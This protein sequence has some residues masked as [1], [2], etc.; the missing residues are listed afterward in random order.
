MD[1]VIPENMHVGDLNIG[2][3]ID[4]QA[5]MRHADTYTRERIA[6]FYAGMGAP[7]NSKRKSIG[8]V[9]TE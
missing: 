7:R 6:I 8:R 3:Q 1:A 9:G 2:K 4:K 5:V